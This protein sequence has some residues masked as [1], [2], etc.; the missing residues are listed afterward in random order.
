VFTQL[1]TFTFRVHKTH[2]TITLDPRPKTG[3]VNFRRARNTAR[4]KATSKSAKRAKDLSSMIELDLVTINLFDMPPMTEYEMYIK[5]Y[6]ASNCAQTGSQ[7]G[8][9][10]SNRE[11]Q[12]ETV[13]MR[14]KWTQEPPNDLK[15]CGRDEAEGQEQDEEQD[16]ETSR[17]QKKQDEERLGKFIGKAGMVVAALL[18]ENLSLYSVKQ[19]K[20]ATGL[21]CSESVARLASTIPL[22]AGRSVRHIAFS[23]AQPSLILAVLSPAPAIRSSD[24]LRAKGFVCVWNL[25]QPSIPQKIL[26]CESQPTCC[27]FG[28]NKAALVV[29]ATVDGTCVMWDLR[30]PASMHQNESVGGVDYLLRHPTYST[31]GIPAALNHQAPIVAISA[32]KAGS[33]KTAAGGPSAQ[34]AKQGHASSAFQ[35]A[36]LDEK[37]VLKTWTVVELLASDPTQ[38]SQELGLLPGGKVKL[39]SSATM[40]LALH[41]HPSD[42]LHTF[43]FELFP[44][45]PNK[46]LVGTNQGKVLHA[47]RFG[48]RMAPRSFA[49]P[50]ASDVAS[51][52]FSPWAPEYFLAGCASGDVALYR[53]DSAAPV[54]KWTVPAAGTGGAGIVWVQWSRQRSV[55]GLCFYLSNGV[56]FLGFFARGWMQDHARILL[57]KCGCASTCTHLGAAFATTSR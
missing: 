37:G 48:D 16:E 41:R 45:T 53:T 7:T 50:A 51:V 25:N 21:T 8:M 14:T 44:D 23:S 5:S 24:P 36:S 1:L 42:M 29:A 27:T 33:S 2:T 22:F 57:S 3:A 52:H 43:C 13:E 34:P 55:H 12:T 9:D 18:E 54:D 39:S 32:I 35:V 40:Q 38:L 17:Q 26:V 4:S 28:P 47:V 30:E 20:T 49:S 15:G 19:Q 10:G 56:V 46:L 31:D 11:V 6:G